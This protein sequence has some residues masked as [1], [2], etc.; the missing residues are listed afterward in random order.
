MKLWAIKAAGDPWGGY[1]GTVGHDT[2]NS[3]A[4][5]KTN[6]WSPAAYVSD[7]PGLCS[8]SAST[9]MQGCYQSTPG[10]AI[11]SFTFKD[12]W[13]HARTLSSD[14]VTC[15]FSARNTVQWKYW[16]SRLPEDSVLEVGWSVGRTWKNHL[17][18]DRMDGEGQLVA[19]LHLC[20]AGDTAHH[21]SKK[22]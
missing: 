7:C 21:Q 12:A 5:L 13:R 17:L 18:A 3:A 1:T 6:K 19:W 9:Q 15:L 11:S 22:H 20:A 4:K 2:T 8:L 10:V 14:T 16:S